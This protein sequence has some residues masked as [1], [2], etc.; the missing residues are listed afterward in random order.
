[1]SAPSIYIDREL[2]NCQQVAP[3]S[4]YY[5]E[6]KIIYRFISDRL[7]FYC[8]ISKSLVLNSANILVLRKSFPLTS[9][10]LTSLLNSKIINWLFAKV[11]NTHKIL[12]ADLEALPL[13]TSW[14]SKAGFD[15]ELFLEQNNIEYSN[16]TFRIKG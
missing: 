4:L 6:E 2:S 3:L 15:E 12:R 13:Y 16:G 7:V 1:M 10:Q 14:Y 5:A 9:Q 8:D 11:F